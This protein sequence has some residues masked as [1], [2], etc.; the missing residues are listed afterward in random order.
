MSEGKVQRDV[1]NPVI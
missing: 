1:R